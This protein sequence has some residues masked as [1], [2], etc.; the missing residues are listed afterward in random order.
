MT[1]SP[2]TPAAP[3][4]TGERAGTDTREPKP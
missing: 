2:S 3:S 4:P 1:P